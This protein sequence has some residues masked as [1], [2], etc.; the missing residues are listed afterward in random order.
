VGTV[1]T[2]ATTPTETG[3]RAIVSA[4]KAT[5]YTAPDDAHA[6]HAYLVRNDAVTILKQSPAGWAY[7]DYV[8]G[9]GKHL[10][11]WIKV[12]QMAIKP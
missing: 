7:V 4:P 8:N 12:D 2:P 3:R 11:R 10:L 9:S 5:L 1:D 6:S